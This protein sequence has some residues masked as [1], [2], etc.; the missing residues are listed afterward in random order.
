[1]IK[2]FSTDKIPYTVFETAYTKHKEA[3]E[4][5]LQEKKERKREKSTNGF[6]PSDILLFRK[7]GKNFTYAVLDGLQK[8]HIGF[9]DACSALGITN[10]NKF[11]VYIN[12]WSKHL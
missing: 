5:I 6:A 11:D 1:M 12:K 3:F 8:G 4:Q 7:N 10:R 2:L 9:F